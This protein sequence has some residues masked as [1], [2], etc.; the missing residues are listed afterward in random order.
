M[1]IAEIKKQC[2]TYTIGYYVYGTEKFM[3]NSFVNTDWVIV[4]YYRIT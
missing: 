2:C 3:T 1:N 4:I